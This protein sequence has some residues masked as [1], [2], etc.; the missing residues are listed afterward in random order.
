MSPTRRFRFIA[1][2][3]ALAAFLPLAVGCESVAG[4]SNL[5]DAACRGSLEDGLVSILVDQHETP[6]VARELAER[7]RTMLEYGQLGPR[8]FVVASSSGADYEFFVQKK[9]QGCLLRLFGR[10]KGFTSYTNNLTY[11]ATRPL[12]GCVC[13]E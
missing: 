8:P 13:Q 1:W 7:T 6:E 3:L 2:P 12:P 11:I 10:T 9:K 4:L 5:S